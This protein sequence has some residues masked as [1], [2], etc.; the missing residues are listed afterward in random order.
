MA[1]ADSQVKRLVYPTCWRGEDTNAFI[2]KW[3]GINS[4]D[5]TA[6]RLRTSLESYAKGLDAS[7]ALYAKAQE[8]AYTAACWLPKLLW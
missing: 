1:Q 4:G 5:S 8:Q 3:S 7:A 2:E 6:V